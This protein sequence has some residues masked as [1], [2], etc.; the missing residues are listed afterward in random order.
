MKFKPTSKT[1]GVVV[2]LGPLENQ[3]PTATAE[4]APFRLKSILVPIDFSECSEKT[5]QYAVPLAKQFGAE[6]ALLHVVQ[7]YPAVPEMAPVDVES[8]QDAKKKLAEVKQTIDKSISTKALVR[9][10]SPEREIVDGARE[11]ASD[12]IIIA[13]HGRTGLARVFLGS[14]TEHVVRQAPCP[15]LVVREREREFVS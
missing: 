10:G 14:T 15:V 1:G 12:L 8:I 4:K 5:L 13:T 7:P 6:L 3:F 2:E 9:L 11:Y